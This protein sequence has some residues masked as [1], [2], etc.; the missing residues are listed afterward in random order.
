MVDI[1]KGSLEDSLRQLNLT[2]MS[3]GLVTSS[4]PLALSANETPDSLNV[5]AYQGHLLFRGGYSLF[6]SLPSQTDGDFTYKDAGNIQHLMVWSNGNLYDCRTGVAV[7]VATAVYTPGQQIA[8]TVLN[9]ILYWAT[10]TVP[11]RQYNGTTEQAVT[12]SGGAGIVAP[13]ACN[14]LLSY[15]GSLIAVY[16]V[17]SGVPQKSSFMWCNVNDPT[18][19]PGVS[20]QTVGSND[21][22]ICTFAILMGVIPG[23]VSSGGGVPATRQL[24]VGKDKGNLFMYQ[25]A[26]GTLTENAI[27]CP[28]GAIDANSPVYIPTQEGLGAVMFLG[29]DAQFWLTNGNS[30]IVASLE[31]EPTVYA[32]TQNAL[33]LNSAQKFNATY[34][35]QYQYYI[36]DF[37]Q[38]T[39]LVYKWDTKAWWLF[40][41]WPSGPYMTA[42]ASSGLPTVFV[43]AQGLGMTGLYQIGLTQTNDNGTPIS[44]YYTTPYLH[45]GRFDVEKIF[46]KLTIAVFNVGIEYTVTAT[47]MPRADGAQQVSQAL[48]LSDPAF[49]GTPSGTAGLWDSATWDSSTWGGGLVSLAQPYPMA[50]MTGRLNVLSTADRWVPAGEPSLF[51][52]GAAQIKVAYN[53]GVPDFRLCGMN[54]AM[55]MRSRGF[56]GQVPYTTEHITGQPP[57]KY[58]N[59]G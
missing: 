7:V 52:T 20:I 28:V 6:A 27:P 3:G 38:N 8:H 30:A 58:V 59:Q 45:G 56:V 18:T 51:R 44:A 12:N 47:T 31:I 29:S 23:G 10:L 32:L 4:G 22:S 16:P 25:G 11:L 36:C 26:L 42:F 41:G 21:G 46:N 17:P 57:D 14:F 55:M 19:W 48:V 53:S 5:F 34:N 9:G 35:A 15:A 33:I 40:Q 54:V 49:G 1:A 43:A 39:Q 2:D 50:A 24:I 37:G 13:P